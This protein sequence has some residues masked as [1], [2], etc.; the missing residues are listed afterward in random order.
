MPEIFDYFLSNF[1]L[2]NN[3]G[4]IPISY[5][6]E[7][8]GLIRV[9]DSSASIFASDSEITV[10][11][12]VWKE[13][14]GQSIPLLSAST[15]FDI[16]TEHFEGYIQ[17]NYDIVASAFFF[18]SGWNEK[19]GS[20]RDA[21]GR[22]TFAGS[23][24]EKLGIRELPVVDYYYDIL[25]SALTKKGVVALSKKWAGKSFA[26]TLTHDIDT[27]KSAWIQGSVSEFKQG[28]LHN[29]P[30]LILSR[31][32]GEDE[33]F[34][35]REISEI[36]RLNNARSTFFF[37]PRKGVIEGIK[38]ADYSIRSTEIQTAI[39]QLYSEGHEIGVHGSYGSS[40]D[41][42]KFTQDIK[43]LNRQAVC[44]NRFH[45]LMFDLF[46]TVTVLESSGIKYDASLGFADHIGFRRSTCS[47]FYLFNFASNR[48]SHVI[49]IPLI[50]MDRTLQHR[51]Y[52]NLKPSE[53]INFI[54]PI[55]EEVKKNNGVLCIL[56]HNIFFSAYKYGGWKSVYLKLLALGSNEGALLTNGS[57]IVD[58]IT[59][60]S[61]IEE[62]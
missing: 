40:I 59:E 32:L 31:F 15:E 9:N 2:T 44:G 24:I 46:E 39:D 45:F 20:N 21:L 5:G 57:H 28:R 53:A 18:L 17:I 52:L 16:I 4:R 8:D 12:F 61:N 19:F 41:G 50:V 27:C 7:S 38:N 35:F 34:N 22:V 54:T 11:S 33:W 42:E 56:W 51:K 6:L 10:N 37:L 58:V 30:K 29:I 23:I 55:L 26:M 60:T 13:W 36:E 1:A 62:R 25:R 3:T 47:P 48:T 14:N 49:E 43:A